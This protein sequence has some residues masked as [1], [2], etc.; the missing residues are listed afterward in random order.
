MSTRRATSKRAVSASS[1]AGS[2]SG[3]S[4]RGGA[5]AGGATGA[6]AAA[7]KRKP[8]F[9][10]A[11]VVATSNQTALKVKGAD[12]EHVQGETGDSA[13]HKRGYRSARATHGV[14]HGAWYFE[15]ECLRG[16]YPHGHMRLGWATS[17]SN[18]DLPVGYCA[19]SYAYR[20]VNGDKVNESFR[21]P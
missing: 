11:T 19:D 6:A 8:A 14:V 21:E 16:N 15:V 18:L 7:G 4:G 3:K 20:D 2:S 12:G 5:G 1:H 9:Q 10:D 17:K 13:L